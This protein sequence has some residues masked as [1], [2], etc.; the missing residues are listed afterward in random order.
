MERV[1]ILSGA[2]SGLYGSEA[3]GGVINLVSA[4]QPEHR[5]ETG[6]GS[7]GHRFLQAETG[8]AWEDGSVRAAVRRATADNAYPFAYRKLVS[9]RDNAQFDGL[10][11]AIGARQRWGGDSLDFN[12]SYLAHDKGIPGPVNYPSPKAAQHDRDLTGALAWTRD[13]EEGPRQRT[14]L[15][16]RTNSLR[17]VDPQARVSPDST[18]QVETTD[19]QTQLTWQGDANG[20]TWGL[21]AAQDTVDGPNFGR[22]ARTSLTTFVHDTWYVSD[23]LTWHGDLR[24]DH[25]STFGLNASPRMGLTYALSPAWRLRGSVGQAFRA[26]TFNDLY[27]PESAQAAGNPTLRPEVTRTYEVGADAQLGKML[28]L[29]ATAFLNQ[30]ADTIMWLPDA[31]NKWTPTNIGQTE[32]RGVEAKA[33]FRPWEPLTLEGSGTWLGALDKGT[34]GASAGKT[35]LY[36]PELVAHV[37]ASV[38]PISPL[39]VSVGWDYT[40]LRFTTAANTEYLDPFALFSA[41]LAYALTER[42][43]LVLRGEN[44]TN[45]TQYVLQPYYPMPGMTLTA[46]WAHVF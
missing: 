12:L 22:K 24:L 38:Q 26:P 10:D 2:A 1:E 42:D 3:V 30:G 17:V 45:D 32:T 14:A 11:L 33:L 27:W 9:P 13:W 31:G 18:T 20:L 43:T 25:Q 46:S 29:M 6:L 41:R 44:L 19:L 15:S 35:L 8:G 34:S 36:R 16:H 7:W 4:Q 40:G 21:G 23:R 28:T 37:G 5:L 39:K